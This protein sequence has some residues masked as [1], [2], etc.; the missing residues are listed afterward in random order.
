MRSVCVYCGSGLGARPEYAEAT[1]ALARAVAGRGLRL[2]YG[3]ASVGLMGVLADAALAAGGEVEGVLPRQLVER[4]L[5]HPG[6]SRLHVVDGMSERKALMAE[7]SDA[8]VALPGGIGTLDELFETMTWTQLDIH[9]KPSG[10]LEV[11][12]YWQPLVALLDRQVAE[13][14]LRRPHAELLCVEEDP[15]ALLDAL[16]AL[17]ARLAAGRRLKPVTRGA[18]RS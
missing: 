6:L 11:A 15:Q 2:V 13:G 16:G 12:G 14:F 1:R 7:R 5:A 4:E 18:A 17:A 10:L 9:D 3:G 8:F